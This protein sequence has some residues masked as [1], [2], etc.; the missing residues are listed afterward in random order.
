[1]TKIFKSICTVLVCALLTL[2]LV[3]CSA[4]KKYEKYA[5][6]IRVAEA[7]EDPFTYAEVLEKLGTPTVNLTSSILGSGE[8]G[9]AT[10]YAGCETQK[11]VDAKLEEGKKVPYIT[12]TFAGGKAT[13]AKT[14]VEAPKEGK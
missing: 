8:S 3:G 9:W 11:D 5:E 2:V 4:E 12:V 1:M 10:W 6:Q 14:G 13:N 7:K